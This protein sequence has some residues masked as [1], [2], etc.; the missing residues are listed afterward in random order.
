MTK[1][2]PALSGK[3][4]VQTLR[5]RKRSGEKIVAL[6]AYDA[7]MARLLNRAEVD[8]ILV[9]DSV[10][11]VKLGF[12]NTLPVTLEHMLHHTQAVRRGNSRAFLVADMPF[13]TYEFDPKEAVRQVG[14][15]MKEGGA[16]AVKV[17]GAGA[18]LPSIRAL[19]GA[20]IPVMGHLGLTP[21]S[22]HRLGGYRVQ[23]RSPS[24]G[25]RLL[26]EARQLEKEGAFALVLEAVPGPLARRVTRA[27]SIPTIG[28][29][30]GKETDGQI[31]VL[32][33]LL[34]FSDVPP[35]RFVKPYAHL[36][37]EALS[38]VRR[39]R[40]DVRSSRFPGPDQTYS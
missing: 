37:T 2:L 17:E 13:L 6:T 35:P 34:G 4:T 20:N 27:L 24:E 18:V 31:L 30:A 14:R 26:R 25:D 38:A 7:P 32:D 15:L 28:I 12:P 29:G 23:G 22:V 3:V 8:V 19:I 10:G 11:N 1:K 40:N 39:F 33:D 5:D 21:Q 16:E 36:W 9:G